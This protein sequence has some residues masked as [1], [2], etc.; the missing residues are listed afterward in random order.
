MVFFI[1]RSVYEGPAGRLVRHFPDETVLDWFRRAWEETK[2]SDADEWLERELGADVYGLSSVFKAGLPTPTSTAGLHRLLKKHLYVEGELR[3][4]EHSVRVLTDDDEVML[5]YFFV[6]DTL[7]AAEPDRWAYLSHDEWALPDV[8]PGFS[9]GR[10][11]VSPVQTGTTTSAPPGG[12]GAT[13]VVMMTVYSTFNSMGWDTPDCFPG[14]RLPQLAATIRETDAPVDKWSA[15]LAIVR[16]LVAPG[17]DEIGSALERCNQWPA[18]EQDLSETFGRNVSEMYGAHRQ[19]H[20]FALR[21]LE[22][23]EPLHGRDPGRTFIRRS[24]HIV[25]MT[26]HTDDRFGYRQWFFFDDVWAAAHPDLAASLLHYGL[27]WDPRCPRGHR[28]GKCVP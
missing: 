12:E 25:Q 5:A 9:G 6:E 22:G 19:A 15:E 28:I 23:S 20:E 8:P 1:Y 18:F 27:H 24:E 21:L 11:F 13:Y 7:V 4:D 26:I 10:P 2:R 16:A 17:E 14:I 3:V